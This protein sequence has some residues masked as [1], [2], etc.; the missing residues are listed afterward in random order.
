MLFLYE[1]SKHI[2]PDPLFV[3]DIFITLRCSKSAKSF[4]RDEIIDAD[5][6]I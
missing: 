2:F 6:A 5:D 3:V 1:I 4:H